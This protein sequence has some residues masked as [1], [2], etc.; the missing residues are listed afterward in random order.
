M[1]VQL[2]RHKKDGGEVLNVTGGL[3]VAREEKKLKKGRTTEK[4]YKYSNFRFRHFEAQRRPLAD[5]RY[6]E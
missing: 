3:A 6:L 1:K 2:L 4:D 5:S